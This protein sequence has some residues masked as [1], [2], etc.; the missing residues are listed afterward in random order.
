[1]QFSDINNNATNKSNQETEDENERRKRMKREME[2]QRNLRDWHRFSRLTH[3]CHCGEQS[4]RVSERNYEKG[5]CVVF[6][7]CP[8]KDSGREECDFRKSENELFHEYHAALRSEWI[9]NYF[10]QPERPPLVYL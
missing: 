8:N 6:F 9:H 10:I 4:S 5:T 2:R 3:L 7:V 1:M